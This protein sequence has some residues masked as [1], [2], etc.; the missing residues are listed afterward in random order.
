MTFKFIQMKPI[1][2]SRL[3]L[4]SFWVLVFILNAGPHWEKYSSNRE[5][6]E[7]VGLITVL[8][9]LVAII[10]LKS[11][12]PRFLD[13]GKRVFFLTGVFVLLIVVSEINILVRYIY[14][15]PVYPESYVQ[16]LKAYGHMNLT[17]RMSLFWTM[18][19]IIFSKLPIF[20]FPAVLLIAHNYY[21]KRQTLLRIKEQKKVAELDAL[22]NQLNPHFIF[23]TLNNIYALSLKKSD[24]TPVA[25]E[26]LSSILDYVVYRC[27]DKFVSLNAEVVLIENYIALEKIRYGKRLNVVI[28]NRIDQDEKIAPLILLTLVENACKHSV[29]EELNE[30]QVSIELQRVDNDLRI[31][32]SNTQ[33]KRMSHIQVEQQVGLANLRKQLQ[34]LYPSTHRF[35]IAETPEHYITTLV[36]LK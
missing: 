31:I 24:Q 23:N 33:S 9:L 11:L 5:L 32:V 10:T 25:I 34:L 21:E 15:E 17:E 2:Q 36:I 3:G 18:R 4:L 6:I 27:N 1:Y 20:L 13:Q 26:K 14:L 28:D 35:E 22:K 30:A 19:Y 8:Q 29:Q 16:F 12:V 7:T